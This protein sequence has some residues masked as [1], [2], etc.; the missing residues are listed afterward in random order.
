MIS[1][2]ATLAIW[3]MWNNYVW[4]WGVSINQVCRLIQVLV[5]THL[6]IPAAR[7]L[8]RMVQIFCCARDIIY[9]FDVCF[10]VIFFFSGNFT[11][12]LVV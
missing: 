5:A 10:S 1:G 12:I 7:L 9:L 6:I 3:I 8:G 11:F 2:V 4:L